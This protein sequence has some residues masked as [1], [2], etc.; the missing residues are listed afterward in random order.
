MNFDFQILEFYDR[1]KNLMS[2][3]NKGESQFVYIDSDGTLGD[4]IAVVIESKTGVVYG[5]QCHG[6]LCEQ[7][8]VEGFLIPCGG[9]LFNPDEGFINSSILRSS[10]HSNGCL[11]N[12]PYELKI[13][14]IADK[15]HQIPIWHYTN[16]NDCTREHLELDLA[17]KYEMCEAWIPVKTKF[18][19]GVLLWNNC[20]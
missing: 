5:T 2:S 19:N 13:E 8:Y 15:V 16:I 12:N 3:I 18:G 7:R 17:R 20:D 9:L 4:W 1:Q 6:V 11:Y 14:E 10:F